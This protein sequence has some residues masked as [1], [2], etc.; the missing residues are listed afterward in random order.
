MK[1]RWQEIA[2]GLRLKQ[3]D[4][5]AIKS[6]HDTPAASL[7]EVEKL[8][9]TKNYNTQ[10]FG[11][12]TWRRLVEVVGN[13]VAGQRPDLALKIAREHSLTGKKIMYS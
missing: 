4:V 2:L 12:P 13:P 3:G 5:D 9:L 11:P 10:K 1:A 6:N 7:R 8:F